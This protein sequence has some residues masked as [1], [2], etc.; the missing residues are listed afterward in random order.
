MCPSLLLVC[1]TTFRKTLC[2]WLTRRSRQPLLLGQNYWWGIN[3]KFRKK[4]ADGE[5]SRFPR[6]RFWGQLV[7][8]KSEQDFQTS[9]S[10]KENFVYYMNAWSVRSWVCITKTL[11]PAFNKLSNHFILAS[12]SIFGRILGFCSLIFHKLFC[13]FGLC[14]SHSSWAYLGVGKFAVSHADPFS[15]STC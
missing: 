9:F 11:S 3:S 6:P 10:I 14:H 15:S 2:A 1:N 8:G 5:K 13:V 12:L 7:K 4:C